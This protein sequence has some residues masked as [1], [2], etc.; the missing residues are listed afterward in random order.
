M[1]KAHTLAALIV[2]KSYYLFREGSLQDEIE[3]MI[4]F[5]FAPLEQICI[6]PL[7]AVVACAVLS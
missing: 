2:P 7:D 1:Y 3:K 4:P 6:E 5:I